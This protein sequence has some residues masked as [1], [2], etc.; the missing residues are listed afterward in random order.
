MIA[1]TTTISLWM[2]I[3]VQSA[4]RRLDQLAV[5]VS[6]FAARGLRKFVRRL[7]QVPG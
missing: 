4:H 6:V 5:Q 7:P 3:V 2:L 1:P